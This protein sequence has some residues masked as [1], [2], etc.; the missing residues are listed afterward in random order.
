MMDAADST[1]IPPAGYN[2]PDTGMPVIV[3]TEQ[4]TVDNSFSGP[5]INGLGGGGMDNRTPTV[6]Q[7]VVAVIHMNQDVVSNFTQGGLPVATGQKTT[8]STAPSN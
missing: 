4:G 1:D 3:N 2:D 8:L 6:G 7:V 5:S